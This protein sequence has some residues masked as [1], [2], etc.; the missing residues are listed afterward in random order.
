MLMQT[1][2]ATIE[3]CREVSSRWWAKSPLP[4]LD[5]KFATLE[6]F[7]CF[8]Y[9]S[10]DSLEESVQAPKF[11]YFKI[12]SSKSVKTFLRSEFRHTYRHCLLDRHGSMESGYN[13][14]EIVCDKHIVFAYFYVTQWLVKDIEF[15]LL[16]YCSFSLN[17]NECR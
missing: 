11:L 17:Y 5:I 6:K 16:K 15:G 9:N 12:Y 13:S 4:L 14:K 3:N 2:L 7:L 8:F 1:Q 10:L